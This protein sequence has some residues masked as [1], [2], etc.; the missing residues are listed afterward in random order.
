MTFLMFS[1]LNVFVPGVVG[2]F[3]GVGTVFVIALIMTKRK[4]SRQA[5]ELETALQDADVQKRL[6]E[7]LDMIPVKSS[8][9]VAVELTNDEVKY[10][11]SFD[12]WAIE[13]PEDDENE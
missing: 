13:E 1:F 6:Y 10:R 5:N 4:Q 12:P 7:L 2:W 8:E 11:G 3:L 9:V